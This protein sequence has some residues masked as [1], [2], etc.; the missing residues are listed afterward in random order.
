MSR[1]VAQRLGSGATV[2]EVGAGT[3]RAAAALAGEGLRVTGI[4]CSGAMLDIQRCRWSSD[5]VEMILGDVREPIETRAYDG[6]TILNNTLFQFG[7][8]EDQLTVLR[9]VRNALKPAGLCFVE[10]YAHWRVATNGIPQQ[11]FSV[12]K[13]GGIVLDT[14]VNDPAAQLLVYQRTVTRGG[15]QDTIIETSRYA[16]IGELRLMFRE[17]GLEATGCF[18]GWLREPVSAQSERLVLVGRRSDQTRCDE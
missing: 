13:S 4:E 12:L 15:R 3:G 14:R 7:D 16:G 10:V 18:G 9:N 6:A 11:G 17:S 1:H 2:L 8:Q 5:Q